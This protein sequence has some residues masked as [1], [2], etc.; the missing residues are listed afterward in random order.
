M[1]RQ[2][3]SPSR[4]AGSGARL[5]ARRVQASV[6]ALRAV[7]QGRYCPS[8]TLIAA[9]ATLLLNAG[10]AH[11]HKA[12]MPEPQPNASNNT[13]TS[14]EIV[15]VHFVIAQPWLALTPVIHS[16]LTTN[17]DGRLVRRVA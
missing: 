14:D 2:T 17:S 10:P 7:I 16:V 8:W 4:T 15:V 11:G 1:P 5:L 6:A 12:Q 13:P 9:I 3:V